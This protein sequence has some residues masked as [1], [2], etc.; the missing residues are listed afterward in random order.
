MRAMSWLL[1]VRLTERELAKRG[2]QAVDA[3]G[4]DDPL[5]PGQ[6]ATFAALALYLALPA[7]LTIAP[8]WRRLP[9]PA[10]PLMTST[11]L[12]QCGHSPA[13]GPGIRARWSGPP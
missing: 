8:R 9:Y 13:A 12:C 4:R 1:D 3:L 7:A 10:P 2:I 11:P 6:R 5:W